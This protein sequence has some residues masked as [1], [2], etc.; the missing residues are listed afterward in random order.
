MGSIFGTRLHFAIAAFLSSVC[1]N[2]LDEAKKIMKLKQKEYPTKELWKK[3]LLEA[4]DS[5]GDRAIHIVSTNIL[6]LR[7][8]L[9][10]LLKW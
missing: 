3:R 7:P 8:L 4:K 2:D 10:L 5:E 6:I 1:S 9:M